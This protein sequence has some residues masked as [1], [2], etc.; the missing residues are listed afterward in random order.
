MSQLRKVLHEEQHPKFIILT[1]GLFA[2][3]SEIMTTYP[4]DTIK[5]QRL[6]KLT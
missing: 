3:F 5:T 1:G 6:L 4:L 2:G